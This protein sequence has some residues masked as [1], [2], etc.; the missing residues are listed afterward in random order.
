MAHTVFDELEC[1]FLSGIPPGIEKDRPFDD[2]GFNENTAA[3][4]LIVTKELSGKAS[5]SHRAWPF[6]A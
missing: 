6:A 2:L 3:G 1:P 4:P 5:C